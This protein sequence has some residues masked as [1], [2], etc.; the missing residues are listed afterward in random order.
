MVAV[1]PVLRLQL[2]V[3][4]VLVAVRRQDHLDPLGGRSAE[5]VVHVLADRLQVLLQAGS[6]LRQADEQ[7]AA[8]G[9]Q[10]RNGHQAVAGP[11]QVL[12]VARGLGHADEGPVVGVHPVVVA[13]PEEVGV[14]A[15]F[16]A[17]HRAPV[18]AAVVQGVDAAVLVAGEDEGL[19][20]HQHRLVVARCR[21]FRLVPHV[22]PGAFEQTAHLF[23]EDLGVGVHRPVDAELAWVVHH[24]VRVRQLGPRAQFHG[25]PPRCG[26][27]AR[28][29][30]GLRERSPTRIH[31]RAERNKT[32]VRLS[33]TCA[34]VHDSGT[35]PFPSPTGP[36]II[37]LKFARRRR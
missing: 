15:L 26:P 9:V 19:A 10:P 2:P 16:A 33:C 1:E 31:A 27:P 6:V 30:A 29:P 3:A 22:H 35:R 28:G 14:S 24:Q 21:Q 13:A 36:S 4:R 32:G 37:G 7:Q 17:H 5:P 25:L 11:V 18:A 12:R 34:A 23:L 8:V 20:A